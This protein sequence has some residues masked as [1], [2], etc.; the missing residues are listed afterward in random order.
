MNEELKPCPFCGGE[1]K[2][3]ETDH[4][5]I[6]SAMIECKKCHA[7]IECDSRNQKTSS[8]RA[9]TKWNRLDP[10]EIQQ[11]LQDMNTAYA[12]GM[13][14]GKPD[15]VPRALTLEELRER[16]GDWIWIEVKGKSNQTGWNRLSID[17]RPREHE[18]YTNVVPEGYGKT[19]LAYDHE[20]KEAHDGR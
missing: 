16:I 11:Q 9:V 19:W 4:G 3:Y 2:L 12:V 13:Q 8:K 18:L 17:L 10:A 5:D 20:P 15:V 6:K 7:T 1:A 14:Q